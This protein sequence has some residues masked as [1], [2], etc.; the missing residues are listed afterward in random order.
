MSKNIR[1]CLGTRKCNL[2]IRRDS[3]CIMKQ[4]HYKQIL[5]YLDGDSHYQIDTNTAVESIAAVGVIKMPFC[6]SFRLVQSYCRKMPFF[7][8][9]REWGWGPHTPLYFFG[10]CMHYCI[11][12]LFC[13]DCESLNVQP[14]YLYAMKGFLGLSNI[15]SKSVKSSVSS[16]VFICYCKGS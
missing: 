16:G 15:K 4:K 12:F 5:K 10:H 3:N 1:S 11:H 8:L 7:F 13:I 9:H 6:W 2:G 14:V